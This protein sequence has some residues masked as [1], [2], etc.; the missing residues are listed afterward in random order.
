MKNKVT[1]K[2]NK[3]LGG[4]SGKLYRTTIPGAW[5]KQLNME[6]D[7]EISL[8]LKD[9]YIVITKCKKD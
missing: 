2:L 8:E 9:N 1:R 5:V 3:N 4:S 6:N 7:T